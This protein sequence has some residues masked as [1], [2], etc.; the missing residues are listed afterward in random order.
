[1]IKKVKLACEINAFY[2]ICPVSIFPLDCFSDVLRKS[3]RPPLLL[4]AGR[5]SDMLNGGDEVYANC[6]V[7][8]QVRCEGGYWG[9]LSSFQNLSR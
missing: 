1:M 6:M 7:I 8:D 3:K 5:P 4:A 2:F 9:H